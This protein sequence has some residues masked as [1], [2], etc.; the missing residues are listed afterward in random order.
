MLR[1]G[2]RHAQ[3]T[4]P[5]SSPPIIS[6]LGTRGLWRCRIYRRGYLG[7]H[8]P[9]VGLRLIPMWLRRHDASTERSASAERFGSA[10]RVLTRRSGEGGSER[11]TL[12][13]APAAVTAAASSVRTSAG[14]PRCQHRDQVRSR[15]GALGA[16]GGS[17]GKGPRRAAS[18]AVNR[19]RWLPAF[20]PSPC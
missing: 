6:F 10:V 20:S 13:W 19:R 4:S 1:A 16:L 14:K 18:V 11:R 3:R 5:D 12:R 9:G 2:T 7:R 15:T 17:G 8:R